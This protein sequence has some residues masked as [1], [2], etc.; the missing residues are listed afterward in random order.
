MVGLGCLPA[1]QAGLSA[2]SFVGKIVHDSPSFPKLT[3]SLDTVRILAVMVEFQKDNDPNTYGNGKFGSVYTKAY[4]DTI[5]DPLPHDAGYFNNHLEFAK[6]Y[7]KKVSGGKLNIVYKI[8]PQII[9][10]PDSIRNYSPPPKNS[11][12]FSNLGKLALDVW[13]IAGSTYSN[14]DFSKY[15]L[16]TIFHA[17][18]GREFTAPGSLGN[19]RDLPSVYL[20]I[21]S[22][23]KI[24]GNDFNGFAVNGGKF[25]IN[26]TMILPSTESREVES[27]GGKTLL[28]QLTTN[29]MIVSSIANHIGL[30]DL[31]NTETGKSAIGRFGLMDGESIFAYSG[32]FPPEPSP[33]EKIYMGWVQP[34]VISIGDKKVNLAAKIT[35]AANDTTILKIPINSSEYFLVE[36]RARDAN[37]DGLNLTYKIRGESFTFKLDKDKGRFQW[38]GVDTLRGVITD[39]DEL[40]WAVPGSGIVIW[41]IDEN[42]INSKIADNQINAD[43]KRRG[44]YVEEA[45]GI[46]DIG[47]EYFDI[48]AQGYLPRGASELDLWYAGNKG[49]YFKN[50][51]APDTKPNTN[52]NTGAN[53]LITIENF[54]AL[55][56]K[57]S[58]NVRFGS[59]DIQ[60][61]SVTKLNL[62]S[63]EKFVSSTVIG[64]KGL[65]AI[66]NNLTTNNYDIQG[67]LKSALPNFSQSN[68]AITNITF[69]GAQDNVLKL[70]ST[71]AVEHYFSAPISAPIVIDKPGELAKVY[72]GTND[73][74][75]YVSNN[76]ID[77]L[78]SGQFIFKEVTKQQTEPIKQISI[79]GDFISV[80][81]K[82]Y[83]ADNLGTSIKFINGT[84]KLVNTLDASS[85]PISIVL[86]EK[87]E[88]FIITNGKIRNIIKINSASEISDFS[89]ADLFNDGQNYILLSNGKSLEAYNFG[90]VMAKNFPFKDPNGENF[91]GIPLA[92]DLGKKGSADLIAMTDKG[93][94][95]AINPNSG[96]VVDGFPISSGVQSA[97]TPILFGEEL[98]TMGPL[99]TYKPYLAVLDQTNQLYIWN[100]SPVQG[101]SYW[102]G[103]YGDAMNTSFVPAPSN[104]NKITEFFPMDKVY[105][106][107]NPV[108]GTETKIRYYV[109]E[110][111]SVKINIFDLA[112]D[113]VAEFNEQASGGFD[114]ETSW[115]VSKVQSGIYYAHIEVK[116][117]S[118]QSASKN[119]KI[120]VIK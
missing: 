119:I 55:S 36:N 63:A 3:A 8:L 94:I 84:L 9:T 87:K 71:A 21:K 103:Q 18:V 76:L 13:K 92:I 73:G 40:D 97:T 88:F 66:T 101:K 7:F 120:A 78:I 114:N 116:G 95:Y 4:G 38:F 112:G 37:K 45:D 96:K 41:H 31:F 22:L 46:Q 19:E 91:I 32:L 98:P 50:K 79:A 25:L 102:G 20:G 61:V 59:G 60:L 74:R 110:N 28:L 47:T 83:F 69:I 108:Y 11:T 113:L 85:K 80:I 58:F 2:Q 100:L 30:P 14:E 34:T 90:G 75:V 107:P 81:T 106:W 5:L 111:S 16:F 67:V 12:D 109:S 10:V 105:N 93:T 39:V 62:T 86:T 77:L 35:A 51:F 15:D 117:D 29:G 72:V 33:W 70:R 115:N 68:P 48:L 6:N 89:A 26:N 53:S 42:I 54:S 27:V 1:G 43:I 44:V 52:S 17:G 65:V 56:N 99:P 64:G 104:T 23:Q 49:K 57:M 24:F 82:N 118:G